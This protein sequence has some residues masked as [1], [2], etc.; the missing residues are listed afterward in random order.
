LAYLAQFIDLVDFYSIYAVE[1]DDLTDDFLQQIME[2]EERQLME[3]EQ[4]SH[5]ATKQ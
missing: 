2:A 4:N 5:A 3:M 1:Q